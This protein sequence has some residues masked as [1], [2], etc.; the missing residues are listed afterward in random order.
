MTT[1]VEIRNLH[2]ADEHL[3]SKLES[4]HVMHQELASR[5]ES[6]VKAVADEADATCR[7]L[8]AEVS[9]RI[10]VQDQ[11]AQDI[12]AAEHRQT[13]ATADVR[14]QVDSLADQLEAL[15]N[16]R[17]AEGARVEGQFRDVMAAIDGER[18]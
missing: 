16:A 9:D 2:A 12:L 15:R 5:L 13:A 11:V 8:Q 3:K 14:R 6:S 1:R 10:R 17:E 4:E 7:S 18:R